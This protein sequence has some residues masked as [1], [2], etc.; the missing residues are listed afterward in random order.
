MHALDNFRRVVFFVFAI[1][2]VSIFGVDIFANTKLCSSDGFTEII[3]AGIIS[4]LC[5][6]IVFKDVHKGFKIGGLVLI[7]GLALTILRFFGLIP[8]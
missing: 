2:A 4:A 7:A 3:F 8:G 6:S 1:I 5:F